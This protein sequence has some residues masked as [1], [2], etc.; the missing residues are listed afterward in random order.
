MCCPYLSFLCISM[1]AYGCPFHLLFVRLGVPLLLSLIGSERMQQ[2]PCMTRASG[3]VSC[4]MNSICDSLSCL[5]GCQCT[6]AFSCFS[7]VRLT[8]G[9]FELLARHGFA[10]G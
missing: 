9:G 1:R 5:I 10:S 7:T 2:E 4:C 6:L 8:D 3:F